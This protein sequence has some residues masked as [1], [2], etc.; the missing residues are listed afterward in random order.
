MDALE[1]SW[2]P[3]V[4]QLDHAVDALSQPGALTAALEYYRQARPGL[5]RRRRATRSRLNR[6]P[7]LD[8]MR[9]RAPRR[10]HRTRSVCARRLSCPYRAQCWTLRTARGP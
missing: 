8:R 4:L 1:S 6:S 3:P 7:L 2:T 10:V 9:C 5:S